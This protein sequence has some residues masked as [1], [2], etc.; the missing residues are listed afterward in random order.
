MGKRVWSLV[1]F[2]IVVGIL[3]ALT[4]CAGLTLDCGSAG[5][6]SLAT[7]NITVNPA[8]RTIN[9]GDRTDY[10]LTFARTGDASLWRDEVRMSNLPAG[11]SA[12]ITSLGPDTNSGTHSI[13]VAIQTSINN[14]SRE[15]DLEMQVIARDAG[16]AGGDPRAI[17]EGM[18][19]ARLTLQNGRGVQL[20]VSPASPSLTLPSGTVPMTLTL[21]PTGGF[22]GTVTLQRGLNQIGN[23]VGSFTGLP[24]TVDIPDANAVVVNFT[25]G[26]AAGAQAGTADL[27][28]GALSNTNP[29]VT[30]GSLN[31]PVQI[32]SGGG[33]DVSLSVSPSPI[34]F[35]TGSGR[36]ATVTITPVNGFTGNVTVTAENVADGYQVT[37]PSDPVAIAGAPV[38][39]QIFVQQ[40][41]SM[42][43]PPEFT[44]RL[45]V[46]GPGVN[47]FVDVLVT[48]NPGD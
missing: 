34:V 47:R 30:V 37:V 26:V 1:Q 19:T 48:T 24:A 35:P 25:L 9:A 45:R 10:V 39:A 7:L 28:I 31:T 18:A 46:Q 12:T 38:D 6:S 41:G 40:V 17:A 42:G 44:L 2:W 33:P 3:T 11:M 16:P 32:L 14:A 5:T 36:P 20:S 23:Q 27:F 21:T 4:G 13:R 15:Y 22:T 29:P 8:S 43:V